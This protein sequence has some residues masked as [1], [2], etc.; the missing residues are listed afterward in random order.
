MEKAIESGVRFGRLKVIERTDQKQH[1]CNM[2]RCT[3]D[4][5]K[6]V[7]VRSDRLRSGEVQSCGCLHDDLL[8][9]HAKKAYVK[10]FVDGTSINK[11]KS[12]QQSNN[13]SG[14]TGVRWHKR[15]GKWQAS[16]MFQG[17]SYHLGYFGKLEEAAEARKKAEEELFEKY[18]KAHEEK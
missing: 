1:A 7:L 12:K 15:I 14:I 16:I 17:V 5:G 13:K 8:R 11:L 10:N 6:D 18:L 4:C 3:C 9:E 2:Y